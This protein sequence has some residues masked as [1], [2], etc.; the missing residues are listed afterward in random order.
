[1]IELTGIGKQYRMG[2]GTVDALR[3]VSVRIDDGE[4][5]AIM[6]PSGSGK[7]TLAH[8]IG[9]LDAPSSGSYLL[10]GREVSGLSGD[11]L[12][13]LRSE[14]IGFVFQQFN[15]LPRL[16]AAAN[17]ALPLL[18]A[19]DRSDRAHALL[20]GLGL[21]ARAEHRPSEL[22]GGQQQ[23]VAIARALVNRP[24]AI[25]ADEPTGN[26]DSRSEKEIIEA[27]RAL[28]E[29]GIT[30]I[31]VTHEEE[32]GAHAQRLIRMRDGEIVSDER[33]KTIPSAC[34]GTNARA[35]RRTTAPGTPVRR[36][37]AGLSPRTLVENFAQGFHAL[38]ANK[39]RTALSVLGIAIG[40]GA[41]V[42]MMALG[43]GAQAA[44]EAQLASLGS[45]LLVLRPGAVRVA[46]VSQEAAGST[47]LSLEDI[48]AILESVPEVR[49]AA[50]TVNGRGQAAF[51]DKNW[52]TTLLGAGA[53]YADLHGLQPQAGRFF[54]EEENKRRARVAVV[55]M[56]LVRQLFAGRNPVGEQL[57]INKIN[58]QVI[59]VLPEKGA[60]GWRDQDDIAIVPVWT[61]MRRLLGK[62]YIDSADLEMTSA[63]AGENAER[64]IKRLLYARKRVPQ[65]LRGEAFQIRNMA[66]IKAALGESGKTMS[67]LLASVAAISLLVGGIG[68]MN[69]MLVSV[70]ERTKE[71]GLRKAIGARS[72]DIL[73]Q[74][75]I[76]SMAVGLVGGLAGLV[77]GWAVSKSLSAFAGW[78]TSISLG[79]AALAFGFSAGIGVIFGIYPARRAARL[80]PIDALR[81]D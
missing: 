26:L 16:S 31:I 55:G 42:A 54:T 78:A 46:G 75:L 14:E 80:N 53:S 65:S 44:I 76:E 41:V 72:G 66:D 12:A 74:F 2:H 36:D 63:T 57:K 58:F 81:Y 50:A 28:N 79:S 49:A 29:R 69:I 73:L 70:T 77:V 56:T 43:R 20:E 30:V 25:L 67:W 9:L 7:S 71:I 23:R 60:N 62:P 1:L 24:R 40:V 68:I 19:S 39:A 6:G 51:R 64:A 52:S 4:F 59:G 35:A 47:R 5:V 21:G 3:S 37:R 38:A 17:V 8:I 61:A 34:A 10:N 45:N 22:S 32:I 33:T 27:L 48:E 13:R 11:A 15:L 18:Y